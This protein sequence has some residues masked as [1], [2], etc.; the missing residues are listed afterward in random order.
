MKETDWQSTKHEETSDQNQLILLS[1][2]IFH[3]VVDD[4]RRDHKQKHKV[5]ENQHGS[6]PLSDDNLIRLID[7]SFTKEFT[8]YLN[9]I[10]GNFHNLSPRT[11]SMRSFLY[12]VATGMLQTKSNLLLR[13][14]K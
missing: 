3:G 6:D 12:E 10:F 5:D 1:E 11:S 9:C 4:Q 13:Q 14:E 8:V 2:S 7:E